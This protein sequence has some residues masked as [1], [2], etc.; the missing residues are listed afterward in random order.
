[1]A[2]TVVDQI[3]EM[4]AAI[5]PHDDLEATHRQQVIAWLDETDDVFRRAKPR[6]PPQHLVSYFL[7]IDPSSGDV[8]LADHV[9]SGLWLPAGGHV[10]PGEHPAMTV[11][12][13]AGEELGIMATFAPWAG[14]HPVFI[15]VTE[16]V[17]TPDTKHTDVSLWF[18]I[19]HERDSPLTPDP[20]EFNAV[21]WWRRDEIA[22][23]DPSRFDPHLNR[24]LAK[25]DILA[26]R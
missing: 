10:E 21:R 6:T 7:V 11:R 25:I 12:R 18:V 16:T 3:R 8:L 19:E 4:V 2:G 23:A 26:T 14:P 5:E 9:R 13:E 17:G 20:D 15:T 22:C 1:M 24:M